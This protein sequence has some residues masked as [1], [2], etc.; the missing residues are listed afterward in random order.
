VIVADTNLVSYL[1]IEGEQTDAVRRVWTKD[2]AWVLPPLWRSEF[3]NVL[4]TA[5]RAGVISQDQA[6][7]AW[8]RAKALLGASEAEPLGEQ[9]LRIA[10]E[11]SVSA[12]DAQFV[13]VAEELGIRLVT[14][15][16]R[17]CDRCPHVA[18]SIEEFLTA[19]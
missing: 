13:A 7:L 8:Q 6:M 18:L 11:R 17:I 4:A 19:K 10:I 5:H 16:K 3:L 15:D 12:Y 1:L 9:V 14:S 2:S